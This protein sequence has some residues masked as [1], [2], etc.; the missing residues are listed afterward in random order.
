[1]SDSQ[2]PTDEEDWFS[3][4]PS[5]TGESPSA[6]AP[7]PLSVVTSAPGSD[8]GEDEE[9]W[10]AG[11][12]ESADQGIDAADLAPATPAAP[13]EDFEE[14]GQR[15]VGEDDTDQF[16]STQFL[17][18]TFSGSAAESP[19]TSSWFRRNR[20]TVAVGGAVTT[21]VALGVGAVLAFSSMSSGD[22]SP[23]PITDLATSAAPPSSSTPTAAPAAANSWCSGFSPRALA[24]PESSDAGMSVIAS[25]QTAFY[26]GDAAKARS[27]V[28][29]DNSIGSVEQLAKGFGELPVGSEACVL[30][31]PAATTG[32]YDV[33]LYER[34][35]DGSNVKYRQTVVTTGAPDGSGARIV[36]INKREGQ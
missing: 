1:M 26:A 6:P 3:V 24:T 23:T 21:V 16:P 2:R 4:T 30:A 19:Q 27:Y 36:A 31:A 35:P 11:T 20:S 7:S 13:D 5:G 10:F 25:F 12:S 17:P 9:D 15:L 29:A 28:A 14:A 32:V 8:A 34:H 22:E 18:R 33:D